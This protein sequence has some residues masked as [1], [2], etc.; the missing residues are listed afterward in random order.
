MPSISSDNTWE[1]INVCAN[2]H[3]PEAAGE[4]APVTVTGQG[5]KKSLLVTSP[6]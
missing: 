2:P 4:K 1:V 3:L 5:M 6:A